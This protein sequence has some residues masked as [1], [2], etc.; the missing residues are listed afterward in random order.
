MRVAG[1]R[2]LKIAIAARCDEGQR[3]EELRRLKG[4]RQ[5]TARGRQTGNRQPH[6]AIAIVFGE[7]RLAQ[8]CEYRGFTLRGLPRL[9][10]G[11][12]E[13][14][15]RDNKRGSQPKSLAN[16]CHWPPPIRR[17]LCGGAI[18]LCVALT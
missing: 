15:Q 8:A 6:G 12:A 16:F 7:R 9:P 13:R 14:R 17:G 5:R 2:E 11:A 3:A 18:S 10:C 4:K 1:K